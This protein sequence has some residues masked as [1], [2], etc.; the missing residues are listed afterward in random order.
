VGRIE[1]ERMGMEA[2][3]RGGLVWAR[4]TRGIEKSVENKEIYQRCIDRYTISIT[5][6][7]DTESTD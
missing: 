6:S 2:E 7:A 5:R 3:Q 1:V 4:R